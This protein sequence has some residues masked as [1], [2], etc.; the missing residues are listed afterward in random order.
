MHDAGDHRIVLRA[1]FS[2]STHDGQ[3]VRVLI[4]SATRL[5]RDGLAEMLTHA[6]PDVQVRS[7]REAESALEALRDCHATVVLIDAG[8]PEARATARDV[9][10]NPC[11]IGTVAF[12]AS[13]D[14]ESRVA[15]AECGVQGYVSHDGSVTE[16]LDATRAA[17]R[18]ELFCPP[19][20]AAALA[21][22]LARV[23]STRPEQVDVLSY[24]E[25][26]VVRLIDEGMS[27]KEI[28]RSLHIEVATVKNHIHHILHKLG[29]HRRGE[30]AAAMRRWQTSK[31]APPRS[32]P[33]AG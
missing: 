4:I 18:G 10:A 22:R 9:S 24:R 25:R 7:A 32:H 14:V 21:R 30:A 19:A 3:Q 31:A 11:V 17:L 29:V 8:M 1:G 28:A 27:N 15:L 13:D 33:R 5:L 2:S 6:Q 26:D 23:H 16:L 20:L 12:A